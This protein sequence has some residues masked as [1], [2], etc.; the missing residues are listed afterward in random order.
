MILTCEISRTLFLKRYSLNKIDTLNNDL[1]EMEVNIARRR[2]AV[3][4]LTGD[5][6]SQFMEYVTKI[7][8]ER[9]NKK[10]ILHQP[11]ENKFL[12]EPKRYVHKFSGTELN[13]E[14]LEVLALGL[15]FCDTRNRVNQIDTDVQFENLDR[16]TSDLVPTSDQ[17]VE[18]LKS[19][20][21]NC[22]YQFKNSRYNYRSILTKKHMEAINELI[23]D[24]NLIITK[25]DKRTGTVL[26]NKK[27]YID[28]MNNILNDFQKFQKLNNQ[29][30][31]NN[32]I[33]N[34][35]TR[36]LKKVQ[37][38]T[39]DS[40]RPFNST[41]ITITSNTTATITTTTKISNTI[42]TITTSN[43]STTKTTTITTTITTNTTN[44][45]STTTTSSNT[46]TATT[47]TDTTTTNNNNNTAAAT[48]S[49]TNTTTGT[50]VVKENTGKEN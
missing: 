50:T 33:E 15:K 46:S 29:N 43:I 1:T 12:T 35:L 26:L 39:D 45:N 13:K 4:E 7:T 14:K 23:S 48:N 5:L 6:K 37:R 21:V 22:C 28:K 40:K 41:F 16:Q 8:K 9:S 49:T 31:V 24:K 11:V 34:E 19:K 17:E 30:D 18:R 44:N 36:S 42:T 2:F 3:D 38:P 32:K 20:L 10:H 25:P 47:T 27:D